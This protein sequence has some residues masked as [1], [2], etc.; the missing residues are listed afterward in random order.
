[1]QTRW[2]DDAVMIRPY[3]A[4]DVEALYEAARASVAEV[5]PWLTWCHEGY[6][7]QEAAA[8][9]AERP[10]AWA[11]GREY[12]FAVFDAPS[13]RYLGGCG[14]NS[15]HPLHRFANLGYW[16][17]TDDTRR[18]V[19]TRAARLVAGFGFQELGLVRLE[20]VVAVGNY[21]SLRVAEKVGARREGLLRHRL[22]QADGPTDAVMFSLIPEDVGSQMPASARR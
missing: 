10:A 20:I 11:A 18:G 12:A 3:G 2:S 1:M 15:I 7:R 22:V 17:R 8:W 14:L 6:S 21:A 9:I 16:V 13:G 5:G 4:G 19:A